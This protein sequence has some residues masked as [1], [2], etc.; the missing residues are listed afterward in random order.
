MQ[1]GYFMPILRLYIFRSS[2]RIRS[3]IAIKSEAIKSICKLLKPCMPP[4]DSS[5]CI[6]LLL[7]IDRIYKIVQQVSQY[8]Q[9]NRKVS[10]TSV[11][12]W[13]SPLPSTPLPCLRWWLVSLSMK[14]FT[15]SERNQQEITSVEWAIA[16]KVATLGSFLDLQKIKDKCKQYRLVFAQR[17]V[18]NCD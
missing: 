2:G 12:T 4:K 13:S 16:N 11:Q 18:Y 5:R 3:T 14:I 9:F 17:I 7:P 1:S 15:L 8:V 6:M 10:P